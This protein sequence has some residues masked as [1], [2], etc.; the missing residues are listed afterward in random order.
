MNNI[1]NSNE[2]EPPN[3]TNHFLIAMPQLE[4]SYFANSL[5]YIWSHSSEGALGLV[6]NLPMEMPLSEVFKQLKLE[7]QRPLGA[8]QTLLTGGPIETDKGFILHEASTTQWESTIAISDKIHIT[9]SRDMLSDIS[10]NKGPK[11]YLVALGCSGWDPGQL[12]QEI[13]QNSWITC[14]ANPEI[15]FST[16]FANKPD[17]AAAT[18]GFTMAQLTPDTGHCS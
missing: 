6:I 18:L 8:N 11:E 5:I 14:P 13:S 10:C 16:D 9:T 15:V 12:E 1:D 2:S 4:G 7:D 17:M 3:F